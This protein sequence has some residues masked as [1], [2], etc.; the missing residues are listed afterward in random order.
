MFEIMQKLWGLICFFFR[1]Q[2]KRVRIQSRFVNRKAELEGNNLIRNGVVLGADVLL[3]RYSYVSG[4]NT[5][6]HSG[7]IGRFCSIAAGVKIGLDEHE[8]H[9]VSTHPFLYSKAFGGFVETTNSRQVKPRPVIGDDVWVGVNSVI[10]R[11]VTVGKGAVIA[12]GSVVTKDVEPY[13]IVGGVPAAPIKKR[14]ADE[15]IQLLLQIDW[16]VWS[17]EKLR[18]KIRLFRDVNEFLR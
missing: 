7:E 10:L 11:G 18:S 16:C 14:F 8:Y 12:A 3:G 1:N 15:E 6:I 9:W 5:I 2:S 4:P 13:T 17:E